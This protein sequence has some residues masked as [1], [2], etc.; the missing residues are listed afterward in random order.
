[1]TQHEKKISKSINLNIVATS[2]L[3]SVCSEMKIKIIY[4]ST[5]YVYQKNKGGTKKVIRYCHGITMVGQ[6]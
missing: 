4:V 5:S 2:N 3:V 1:M 6:N